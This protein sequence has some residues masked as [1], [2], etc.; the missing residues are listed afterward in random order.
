MRENWIQSMGLE[1]P[2]E[3]GMATYSSILAWG[4]PM[5]RGAWGATVHGV[6]KTHNWV[7]RHTAFILYIWNVSNIYW[8]HV[9]I[10]APCPIQ[11]AQKWERNDSCTQCAQ[12]LTQHW[13]STILQLK[14]KKR[15]PIRADTFGKRLDQQVELEAPKMPRKLR[16]KTISLTSSAGKTG[17]SHV[18]EWN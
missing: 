4:V 10:Q 14:K 11:E 2:L 8:D 13:K 17:Q 6:T 16:E 12:N 9:I 15:K 18:K 1:D 3:E 5:D 7:T